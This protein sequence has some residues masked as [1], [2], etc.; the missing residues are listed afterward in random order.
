MHHQK[1]R[2]PQDPQRAHGHQSTYSVASKCT[3]WTMRIGRQSF[4]TPAPTRL[5]LPTPRSHRPGPHSR[6]MKSDRHFTEGNVRR[7][8]STQSMLCFLFLR[9]CELVQL[10]LTAPL[11]RPLCSALRYR[12]T[13][14]KAHAHGFWHSGMNSCKQSLREGVST[15]GHVACSCMSASML[16]KIVKR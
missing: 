5:T 16:A 7:A 8:Q 12:G 11:L 13:V 1:P 15:S 14:G 9:K 4:M 6:E 10:H 2:S 3:A